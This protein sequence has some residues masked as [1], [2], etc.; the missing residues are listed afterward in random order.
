MATAPAEQYEKLVKK[1]NELHKR[2]RELKERHARCEPY[3]KKATQKYEAA[4]E[5][6]RQ[7]QAYIDKHRSRSTRNDLPSTAGGEAEARRRWSPLVGLQRPEENVRPISEI[8]DIDA[9]TS[10]TF[11]VENETTANSSD[12]LPARATAKIS[13]N[14]KKHSVSD[15]ISSSQTTECECTLSPPARRQP[16]SDDEP[17]VVSTWPVKRRRSGSAHAMPPPPRIKQEPTSPSQAIEA[18]SEDYNSPA[19]K[20]HKL[21]RTETSNLDMPVRPMDTPRKRRHLH[22]TSTETARPPNLAAESS[23]LSESDDREPILEHANIKTEPDNESG[24]LDSTATSVARDIA[25]TPTGSTG[26]DSAI[27][28]QISPNV[29]SAPRSSHFGSKEKRRAIDEHDA[30]KIAALSEAGEGYS[31]QDGVHRG[32]DKSKAHRNRRLDKLLDKPS[33]SR[34]PLPRRRSPNLAPPQHRQKPSLASSR[35]LPKPA[36]LKNEQTP[37]PA[38]FRRPHGLERS[39]PPPKPEDEPLRS[40]PATSLR[41]EDFKINPEY[42]GADY[43]FTETIR[44]REQRRCLQGCTRPE[45][46]GNQFRKAVKIGGL[47]GDK[48][49]A[50]ALEEYLGPE[51]AEAMAACGPRA[52]EDLLL[53]ARAQAFANQHGKHRHAFE[54]R[55]TPPGFWRTDMPTTQEEEEDRAKARGMLRKK[56]EERRREAMV[57][58]GRWLFRDE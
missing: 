54:R 43:A 46:C 16:S 8:R 29:V 39:P 37:S 22:A 18:L 40:R 31:N 32:E 24:Q 53:Q 38:T 44:G 28:R 51:F 2:H 23:T 48:S 12:S 14:D 9:K 27:L 21:I 35:N 20:R 56:I 19:Q 34:Q 36:G 15:R 6:A 50:Q 47:Q 49:D 33:P 30:A 45:C 13:E 57:E 7:W 26:M 52:R 25:L 58:G 4:K 55:S 17:E 42:M 11:D 1:Y 3:I 10:T 41:L 5:S